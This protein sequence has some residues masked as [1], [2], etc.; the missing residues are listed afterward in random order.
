VAR[1]LELGAVKYADL[2]CSLRGVLIYYILLGIKDGLGL[3]WGNTR[4]IF[5]IIALLA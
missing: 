3:G 1:P 4:F 5:S 2:R